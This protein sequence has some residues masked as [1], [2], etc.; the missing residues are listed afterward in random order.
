MTR[1]FR[2]MRK[3]ASGAPEIGP[4]ARALGVRAGVDI[5]AT[6]PHQTVLPGQGGLSVSPDDPMN[7]PY[8]R[9]PPGFGGTGRDPVWVI[10]LNDLGP[11]L[12]YRSDPFHPEHGFIEPIQPMSLD[13][14]QLALATTRNCWQ[15]FHPSP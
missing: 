15:E 12:F 7:L 14:Y 1:L 6:L 4:N 10:D 5:P 9:R 3:D 8:F 2:A 11:D 13:D